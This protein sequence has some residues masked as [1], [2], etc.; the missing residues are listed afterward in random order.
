[1]TVC[2]VELRQCFADPGRPHPYRRI[3]AAIE[4]GR[5]LQCPTADCSLGEATASAGDRLG[6]D[7]GQEV[8]IPRRGDHR[9]AVEHPYQLIDHLCG[10]IG[11]REVGEG[12]AGR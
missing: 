8:S 11:R 1:M 6:D 10:F 7:V 5:A 4:G 2:G 3:E 12:A 9:R